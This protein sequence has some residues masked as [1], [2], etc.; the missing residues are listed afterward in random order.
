MIARNIFQVK[1]HYMFCG[2]LFQNGPG[3]GLCHEEGQTF[4]LQYTATCSNSE[5]QVYH[6]SAI[7]SLQ[8][9]LVCHCLLELAN[10]HVT[11]LP[12]M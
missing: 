6:D 8:C 1:Y 7:W 9:Q 3:Y 10:Q 5:C 12:L 11:E 2:L 4:R